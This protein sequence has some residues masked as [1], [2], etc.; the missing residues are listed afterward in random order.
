ML[1][2]TDESVDVS[3]PRRSP[4]TTLFRNG[5]SAA[6]AFA[7]PSR[8]APPSAPSTLEQD[9]DGAARE[10]VAKRRLVAEDE[11]AGASQEL[12]GGTSADA[13]INRDDNASA[14]DDGLRHWFTS[15]EHARVGFVSATQPLAAEQA[16]IIDEGVKVVKHFADTV[17]VISAG[18]GSGK[19]FA[20][21]KL[22]EALRIDDRYSRHEIVYT[23][24]NKAAAAE[25]RTSLN[26]LCLVT[27]VCAAASATL[28]KSRNTRA[29]IFEHS[30]DLSFEA[31]VL[32]ETKS[33]FALPEFSFAHDHMT[34]EEVAHACTLF[35][36]VVSSF[37]VDFMRSSTSLDIYFSEDAHP[38]DNFAEKPPAWL[39]AHDSKFST[40][41]PWLKIFEKNEFYARASR[42]VWAELTR[43]GR[44]TS[45]DAITKLVAL[46]ELEL[47]VS[48]MLAGP[49]ARPPRALLV[50]EAQDLTACQLEYLVRM[51]QRCGILLVFV[52]D[53]MQN[54]YSFR[55]VTGAHFTLL[56][57]GVLPSK[58]R[59]AVRV[60]PLTTCYR[61]PRS[62][63]AAANLLL[64][65]R[66][67]S[68]QS[69]QFVHY[70]LRPTPDAPDGEL[71]K[72]SLLDG[73]SWHRGHIAVL[74]RGRLSLLEK[75]FELLALDNPP[76][77]RLGSEENWSLELGRCRMLYGA[78]KTAQ[79]RPDALVV[80]RCS[81]F[82]KLPAR[83]WSDIQSGIVERPIPALRFALGVVNKYGSRLPDLLLRLDALLAQS[84]R[85]DVQVELLTVHAAKGLQWQTVELL[86]DLV[87]LAA[88][89]VQDGKGGM[90]WPEFDGDAINLWYVA[91]T[92]ATRTLVVPPKF[93]ALVQDM[94]SIGSAGAVSTGANAAGCKLVLGSG[95]SRCAFAHDD[96]ERLRADLFEPWLASGGGMV[97][98]Q[99]F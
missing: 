66:A 81:P 12:S 87:E 5:E 86:D 57:S 88:F 80:L 9:D 30:G 67:R 95:Q 43:A 1:S 49:N 77:L 85:S 83:T 97:L 79:E 2:Q 29:Q 96:V 46:E 22:I 55:G 8:S 11:G 65:L 54:I 41:Q 70:L 84:A 27:T 40:K 15:S 36:P 51:A 39:A 73:G 13:S 37:V 32:A 90:A 89:T 78:W 64:T 17:F 76:V 33:T 44:R 20:L 16:A 82:D 7:T 50:D 63:V 4:S 75:A 42:A 6:T 56:A 34:G 93:V 98:D 92:R 35:A 31:L 53:S 52:G 62:H 24:F 91:V 99:L 60:F 68:A 26:N 48:V 72:G 61:C 45:F 3:S 94:R 71:L 38:I 69:A 58:R 23:V 18:A 74:A 21:R 28:A 59:V 10:P 25:A 19:T 47:S 14:C